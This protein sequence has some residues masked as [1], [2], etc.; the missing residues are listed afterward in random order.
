L[1]GAPTTSRKTTAKAR[2]KSPDHKTLTRL[3]C[4]DLFDSDGDGVNEDMI[5]WVIKEPKL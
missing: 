3:M 5:W 2:G 4:F 1:Q